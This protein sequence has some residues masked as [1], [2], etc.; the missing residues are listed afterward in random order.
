MCVRIFDL[1]FIPFQDLPRT[2]PM[3]EKISN[4]PQPSANVTTPPATGVQIF[5]LSFI[6]F[7]DSPRTVTMKQKIAKSPQPLADVTTPPATTVMTEVMTEIGPPSSNGLRVSTSTT[8]KKSHT[9]K[10][11]LPTV[12]YFPFTSPFTT[13]FSFR[14]LYNTLSSLPSS[15]PTNTPTTPYYPPSPTTYFTRNPY[16]NCP[17]INSDYEWSNWKVSQKIKNYYTTWQ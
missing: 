2:G 13:I 7:Q 14:P 16:V 1:S 9:S 12:P 4:S 8:E 11:Q 5:D 17:G 3:K 10:R 6:Q 15:V